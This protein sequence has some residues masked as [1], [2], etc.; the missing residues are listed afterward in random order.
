MGAVY[1]PA[2]RCIP[3]SDQVLAPVL[4]ETVII[5]LMYIASKKTKS[6]APICI[7]SA[8]AA[9]AVFCAVNSPSYGEYLSRAQYEDL[10]SP[11]KAEMLTKAADSSPTRVGDITAW[12]AC[13]QT[14]KNNLM[15]LSIYSSSSNLSYLHLCHNYL[16]LTTAC[17]NKI[18]V[19]DTNDPFFST[20]MGQ[21]WIIGTK[22]SDIYSY[23][24][25]SSQD[26][27]TLYHSE[28]AYTLG[29]AAKRSITKREF[30]NLSPADRQFALLEYAVTEDNDANGHYSSPFTKIDCENMI[31]LPKDEKGW[32]ADPDQKSSFTLDTGKGERAIYAVH[33]K[34]DRTHK[35]GIVVTVNGVKN[36]LSG[37]QNVFPND[38][39]D[40]W[41][42]ISDTAGTGKLQFDLSAGRYHIPLIE[43]FGMSPERYEGCSS[44][45]IMANKLSYN[46]D[47]TL[48]ADITLNEDGIFLFT[49][50]YDKGFTLTVDG[51]PTPIKIVDCAFIGCKLEAG[52]HNVS[53]RYTP[54]YRTA[55]IVLSCV[56]AL[57][58]ATIFIWDH[59]TP[60]KSFL[61]LAK[62][63]D[64]KTKVKG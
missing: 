57:L 64:V 19:P 32:R 60:L 34:I 51:K 16:S 45:M 30:E 39:S 38:N 23:E 47:D 40:M 37:K 26:K 29:F 42:I 1:D 56:G 17:Y 20:L 50:P 33:V 41:F 2:C 54:P 31:S 14:Y 8:C 18:T 3:F 11:A 62:R 46:G 43:V 7:Y 12:Y 9:L 36:V 44:N 35:K 52:Q 58:L 25:V 15:R 59:R 55:G 4:F 49:I 6:P 48:N 28:D 5:T 61:R 24:A 21:E 63:A 13:N 10:T 22:S 27:W 53:L